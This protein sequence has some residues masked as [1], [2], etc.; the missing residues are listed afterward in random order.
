[1]TPSKQTI[2]FSLGEYR[3][4]VAPS[5]R[6]EAI[7]IISEKR[8]KNTGM[9]Q[10]NVREYTKRDIL[11]MDGREYTQMLESCRLLYTP[12][13]EAARMGAIFTQ[14]FISRLGMLQELPEFSYHTSIHAV[15]NRD[16]QGRLLPDEPDWEGKFTDAR[17]RAAFTVEWQPK[18]GLTAGADKERITKTLQLAFRMF[19][20]E[21]RDEG[22]EIGWTKE[23]AS[24]RTR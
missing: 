23:E 5:S 21:A 9:S 3:G 8:S 4:R 17:A 22:Y 20:M 11:L 1:M 24:P 2:E 18:D 19:R 10:S 15:E 6:E 14:K 12:E 16:E 7:D 13:E